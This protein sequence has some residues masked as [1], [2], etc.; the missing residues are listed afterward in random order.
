MSTTAPTVPVLIV[1]GGP[2]G[3][4]ARALLDRWQVPSLLVERYPELSPFPRSRLVTVRSMEIFRRL[5]VAAEISAGA[6]RREYGRIRFSDGM[7]TPDYASAAMVGVHAP[8]AESPELGVVTSQDRLEPILTAAGTSELRFGHELVD[9]APAPD[10]VLTT[11][12][13][14]A[15]GAT[16]EVRA[17]HVVAADGTG[18]PTRRLLGIGTTGP[19]AIGESVTIFFDADLSPWWGDRPAGVYAT[20]GGTVLPVYPEGTWALTVPATGASDWRGAVVRGLGTTDVDVRILRVQPWT[21][22]AQVSERLVAG[23]VLLAGDAAHAIPPAGGMGMNIGLGDVHNLCW[24]LAGVVHGWSG[25]ELLDTYPVERMPV[26]L[27]T[28]ADN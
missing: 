14:R 21:A 10:G 15:A 19:G 24:K 16:Y 4:T 8:I 26:R 25:P 2:V 3:L 11:V 17:G 9:L 23:R 18:S 27:G 13:D 12:L 7:T 20:A 22:T 28:G 6:F 5:G 1:G